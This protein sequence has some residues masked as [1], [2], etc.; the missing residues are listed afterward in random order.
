MAKQTLLL[1]SIGLYQLARFVVLTTA[2]VMMIQTSSQPSFSGVALAVGGAAI[3]PTLLLLQLVLTRSPALVAPLRVALILQLVGATVTL[4]QVAVGRTSLVG[5]STTTVGL[6]GILVLL[7]A[8][9]LL[10]LLLLTP[11]TSLRHPPE[12]STDTTDQPQISVEEV[13]DQ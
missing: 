6:A 2:L 4:A 3:L 12:S 11:H 7:D 13:E 10:F 8:A 9:S 5:L 1:A